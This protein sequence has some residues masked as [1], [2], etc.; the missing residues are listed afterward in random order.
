MT[1]DESLSISR[2]FFALAQVVVLVLILI[3]ILVLDLHAADL[4]QGRYKPS[5]SGSAG[6]G[7]T[8]PTLAGQAFRFRGEPVPRALFPRAAVCLWRPV[9]GI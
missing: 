9:P 3:L 5:G 4:E 2:S 6:L 8:R 7:Q 1:I